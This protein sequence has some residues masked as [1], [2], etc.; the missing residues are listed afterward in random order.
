M[1]PAPPHDAHSEPST[2]GITLNGRFHPLADPTSLTDLLA[3]L[4]LS[5]KPVVI[6]LNTHPV[7]VSLHP[8]TT[9]HPGDQ[10]E[11]VTLAAGG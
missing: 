7:P 6:E 9:V 10:M 8:Q 5:G 2:L 1:T 4:G 3:H 11:I